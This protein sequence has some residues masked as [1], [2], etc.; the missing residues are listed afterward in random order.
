MS[1][2]REKDADS[3]DNPAERWQ[4][5][6]STV[7]ENLH[8]SCTAISSSK[9]THSRKRL[10]SECGPTSSTE[11]EETL[12][13][14]EIT[15]AVRALVDVA[16][17]VSDMTWERTDPCPYCNGTEVERLFEATEKVNHYEDAPSKSKGMHPSTE[18]IGHFC[19]GCDSIIKISPKGL[20]TGHA[21]WQLDDHPTLHAALKAHCRH[22]QAGEKWS[23]GAKCTFCSR[24]DTR[25]SN[26]YSE[27]ITPLGDDVEFHSDARVAGGV[28]V[29]CDG[30][31]ETL[32]ADPMAGIPLSFR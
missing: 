21:D 31:G 32:R 19:Y 1:G 3:I 2:I 28:S 20:L 22:Q 4:M 18:L 7:A 12:S 29:M 11:S 26:V 9:Q 10:D 23:R 14:H 25:E 16:I 15:V 27:T 30:C 17:E 6:A 24:R 13:L 5:K 8:N